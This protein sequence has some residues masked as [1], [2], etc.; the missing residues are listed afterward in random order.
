MYAIQ[1]RFKFLLCKKNLKMAFRRLAIE[2]CSTMMTSRN[3]AA[4]LYARQS[5]SPHP[6]PNQKPYTYV[7]RRART[8]RGRQDQGRARRGGLQQPPRSTKSAKLCTKRGR[9]SPVRREK[10][11][12]ARPRRKVNQQEIRRAIAQTLWSAAAIAA[13]TLAVTNVRVH[14]AST[15]IVRDRR[16][17]RRSRSCCMSCGAARAVCVPCVRGGGAV[18]RPVVARGRAKTASPALPRT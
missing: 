15:G 8:R 2:T 6:K 14:P 3:T 16:Q 18:R 13:L 5:K 11:V 10:S 17:V 1:A 12:V 7:V 9:G 4:R